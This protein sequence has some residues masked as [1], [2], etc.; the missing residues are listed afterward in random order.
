MDR[1]KDR[2][3]S[4]Q[5]P[6][7][8]RDS[9]TVTPDARQGAGERGVKIMSSKPGEQQGVESLSRREPGELQTGV[10]VG[11]P[12]QEGLDAEGKKQYHQ[13]IEGS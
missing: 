10:E 11:L 5:S 8:S 7:A 3:P 9:Q 6:D 4:E 1:Y 13:V 2:E 12:Q